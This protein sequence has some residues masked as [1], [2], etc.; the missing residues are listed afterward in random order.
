MSLRNLSKTQ[1]STIQSISTLWPISHFNLN[2]F[3]QPKRTFPIENFGNF[4]HSKFWELFLF[5]TLDIFPIQDPYKVSPKPEQVFLSYN[6]PFWTA[7]TVR[8]LNFTKA[9]LDENFTAQV[10]ILSII[11]RSEDVRSCPIIH[12]ITCW[13]GIYRIHTD[14]RALSVC[15]C[16]FRPSCSWRVLGCRGCLDSLPGI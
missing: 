12:R 3:S 6:I 4:S 1:N 5:K 13:S 9:I 15:H 11:R 10:C 7:A 16:S 2:T 14:G 8:I